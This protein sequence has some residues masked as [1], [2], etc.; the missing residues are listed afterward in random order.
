MGVKILLA[1]DV[2]SRYYSRGSIGL[3]WRQYFQYGYWKVRVMQKHPRQMRL[4]QFVPPA[5][6]A[7][8][9]AI[10]TLAFF[11]S[12]G[13]MLW[14]L[15]LGAYMLTNLLASLWT[16]RDGGRHHLLLLPVVFATLHISYGLGFLLGL[17]R[18]WN[19][20]GDKRTYAEILRP[21][22]VEHPISKQ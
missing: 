1:A 11:F 5:F 20:W 19:R 2:H 21:R 22:F 13:R 12:F 14:V 10:T 6:V 3:L 16:T 7:T 15:M 18:F 4:R 9:L 17:V 8:L